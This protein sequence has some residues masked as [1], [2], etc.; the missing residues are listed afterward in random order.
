MNESCNLERIIKSILSTV[1]TGWMR[2][3]RPGCSCI[4]HCVKVRLALGGSLA[5][6]M[7]L[8]RRL[9]GASHS[10]MIEF[11]VSRNDA[12][13]VRVCGRRT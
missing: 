11:V 2:V 10:W 1:H 13:D 8:V 6:R 7:I 9:E 12:N 3:G 4:V 5:E